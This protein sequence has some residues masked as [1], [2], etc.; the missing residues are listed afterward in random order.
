MQ[1]SLWFS[2]CIRLLFK[3]AKCKWILCF[4]NGAVCLQFWLDKRMLR[5]PL[6]LIS[7]YDFLGFNIALE[8]LWVFWFTE[9]IGK[10]VL[11]YLSVSNGL[12]FL[13]F[14]S[15]VSSEI[16]TWVIS[17]GQAFFSQVFWWRMGWNTGKWTSCTV[18]LF[19]SWIQLKPSNWVSH[20]KCTLNLSLSEP[21]N[22][23]FWVMKI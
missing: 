20:D 2:K 19:F 6:T 8:V 17:L 14:P 1:L 23:I 16:V 18:L 13:F 9:Y 5:W 10:W 21:E 7:C 3:Y 12:F 4:G 22:E 15:A 11:F